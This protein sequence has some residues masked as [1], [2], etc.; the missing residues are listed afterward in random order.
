M[1]ESPLSH[2]RPAPRARTGYMLWFEMQPRLPR[3]CH[4]ALLIDLLLVEGGMEEHRQP[5]RRFWEEGPAAA[6][7]VPLS[8][9]PPLQQENHRGHGDMLGRHPI[10]TAD[11]AAVSHAKIPSAAGVD[12]ASADSDVRQGSSELS[13]LPFTVED[14][15]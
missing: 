3:N 1:K 6:A 8:F 12:G 7:A 4:G 2:G 10:A 14:G 5:S 13:K 15:E 9:S 11:A